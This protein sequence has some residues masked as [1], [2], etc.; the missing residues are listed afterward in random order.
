M[1]FWSFCKH[2]NKLL[3]SVLCCLSFEQEAAN[4]ALELADMDIKQARE[5]IEK[6]RMEVVALKVG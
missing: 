2:Q 6:Y 4:S 1:S 5:V 3:V